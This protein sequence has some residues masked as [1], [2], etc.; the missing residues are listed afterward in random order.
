MD[1]IKQNQTKW[2]L[3]SLKPGEIAY[4][5]DQG[6]LLLEKPINQQ[7]PNNLTA[8]ENSFWECSSLSEKKE[9]KEK[10]NEEKKNSDQLE[11]KMKSIINPKEL[12]FYIDIEVAI[13]IQNK[14]S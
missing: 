14:V 2:K 7:E 5:R 8:N 4:H 9:N 10:N 6:Y 3:E 1:I 11:P 13:N 12:E